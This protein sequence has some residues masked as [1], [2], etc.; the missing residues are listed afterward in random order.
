MGKRMLSKAALARKAKRTGGLA[1][2]E[3][4]AEKARTAGALL[5]RTDM[6]T[7][8]HPPLD[9]NNRLL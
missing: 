4:R 3:S 1:D 8:P 6:P 7:H 9:L 5:Y 2:T